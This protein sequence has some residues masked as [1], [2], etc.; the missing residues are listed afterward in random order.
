[1]EWS[2]TGG[3]GPEAFLA[4]RVPNLELDALAIQ[5]DSTNLEVNADSCDEGRR[6][7]IVR[8]TKQKTTLADTCD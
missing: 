8:E 2:V 1:M 6:E 5:F 3:D 7:R 4:G